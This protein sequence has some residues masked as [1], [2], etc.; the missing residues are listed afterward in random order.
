M[1]A[2]VAAKER[3]HSVEHGPD[4]VYCKTRN[5]GDRLIFANFTSSNNS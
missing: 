3:E 1:G 5:F 2:V 4:F